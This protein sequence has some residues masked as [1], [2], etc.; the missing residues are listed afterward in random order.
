[1]RVQVIQPQ[2][3]VKLVACATTRYEFETFSG[4]VVETKSEALNAG[5]NLIQRFILRQPVCQ[6]VHEL[7]VRAPDGTGRT[8]RLGTASADVPAQV[9]TPRWFQV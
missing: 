5:M 4:T 8:F 9:R 1:M 7:V 2:E 3:G 6:A